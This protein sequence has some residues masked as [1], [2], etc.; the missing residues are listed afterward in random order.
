MPPT[1]NSLCPS[2]LCQLH[3][4][5]FTAIGRFHI[6]DDRVFTIRLDRPEAAAWRFAIVAFVSQTS[7]GSVLRISKAEGRL[8][9]RLRAYCRDIGYRLSGDLAPDEFYKGG[10]KPW[11]GS[12]WLSYTAPSHAGLLFAQ[13]TDIL[14]H[15]ERQHRLIRHYNPPL[16][17]QSPAGRSLATAWRARHGH[18]MPVSRRGEARVVFGNPVL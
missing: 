14:E 4:H 13:Q 10:T 17:S 16:C 12:A 11:E 9:T 15:A 5:G 8:G 6:E 3:A 18:P 7:G 2:I 1:S